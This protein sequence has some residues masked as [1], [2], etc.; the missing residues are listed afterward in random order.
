MSSHAPALTS[1]PLP[2]RLRP[3]AA[4]LAL[5][6][7]ATTPW[8]AHAQ[9][10]TGHSLWHSALPAPQLKPSA[11]LQEAVDPTLRGQLPSY[12]R[13]EQISGQADINAVLEGGA[14]LRR[15]D[16]VIRADRVEYTLADDTVHAQGNVH[17]NRAGNV[18]QGTALKMQVDAFQGDFNNAT[19]QFLATQ[20][21]GDADRVQFLDR[22][23]SVVYRATYTTCLRDDSASWTPD[24]MIRA[25]RIELDHV[26]DVGVAY[27]GALEFK[28]VPIL[29][30][31]AISFPLSDKRKSGLLPPTIGIDSKSG[32][33]YSQPY[34]WNIAPNRDATITPMLM[35]KRGVSL[36]TQ[37]RYL[38][39]GYNGALDLQ[40]MPDD[41]LRDRARWAYGFKHQGS[42]NAPLGDLGL[43]LN[44]NRVSDDNY[45]RDF[46]SLSGSRSSYQQRLIGSDA[47]LSWT[48]GRHELSLSAQRWQVLQDVDAPI[49]PPFNR[50]PQ[51]RWN[52]NTND[53]AAQGWDVT[54]MAETTRFEA[55]TWDQRNNPDNG[56]RSYSLTS[57]SRP[58]LLPGGF[59]TPKVQL[60][61]ANYQFDDFSA[62]RPNNKSLAI[63]TFSLDSG[64]V[65]ERDTLALGRN[66]V[67][68][69]EPRAFYTY[70]PYRDQ[71]MLPLYD[72][73]LA[74][75]NFGSI[76]SEN[77]YTGRDRIADNHMVT[78]GLT[79][80]YLNPTD[81]AEVARFGVAQRLRFADQRVGLGYDT[82]GQKGWSDILIG[83]GVNWN[84]RWSTDALVQ[85][86]RDTQRTA[87]SA[88]SGRYTPGP[89]KTLSAAYRYQRE[90]SL[91]VANQ[92]SE[93]IDFGWQWPLSGGR[94]DTFGAAPS[95]GRWYSVGRLNYS[96]YDKK[97]VD[98][99]VGFE[100]DSCCWIGRVVVE[101]MQNSR[102]DSNTRL[103]FQ[104][105]FVGFSRLSLGAD[106]LRS[107]QE[108]VPG[109]RPLRDRSGPV[110]SRFSNYD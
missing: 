30:V 50:M 29:P 13:A 101:R 43:K 85:Y 80:R 95:G 41:K 106:P 22:D 104:L 48:T 46:S 79:T 73:A 11:Q 102:S 90:N 105:E 16:T 49:A 38:E 33:E 68:T 98:A 12:I 107:L 24:W 76:Y 55:D 103:L 72:T 87:R 74:D 69:L 92:G 57:L 100:Y 94:K 83:A 89:Y 39:P 63:P 6:W 56:Q 51:L 18:Y 52:Y 96:M 15:A 97:L 108:N 44:L 20:G 23:H 75:F 71:S 19:Y 8:T 91:Q 9:G 86:N 53:W 59:I 58:F 1:Q 67:Q 60:H 77:S 17:I 3:L 109:Y 26:E 99:I 88:I 84:S 10:Q 2:H 35:S 54:L 62:S 78:L 66:Y 93:Q 47:A 40:Y 32:V 25:D 61:A 110:P 28:G 37:F 14:E 45:W 7:A 21:H 65:F 36:G 82:L 34:Y 27:G 81:G 4:S 70:T 31:P 64:L 5:V 42:L